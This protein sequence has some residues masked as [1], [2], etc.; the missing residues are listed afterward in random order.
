MEE[1]Y[2][3]EREDWG[4]VE[5]ETGKRMPLFA[6]IHD[7][8]ENYSHYSIRTELG[9]NVSSLRGE[10][11]YIHVR[12]E[13]EVPRIR[14]TILLGK[15]MLALDQI[16]EERESQ[17]GVVAGSRRTGADYLVV[18][19]CQAWY[20]PADRILVLWETKLYESNKQAVAP[21]DNRLLR[22]IWQKFEKWLLNR[23]PQAER[24]ATPG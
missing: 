23:F 12:L 16:R 17:I 20:Y 2:W 24:I 4:D 19:S 14:L 8:R 9:L 7:E 3:Q 13:R 11:D 18:G 6:R 22:D 10:R 5:L 1:Q 21:V 15:S